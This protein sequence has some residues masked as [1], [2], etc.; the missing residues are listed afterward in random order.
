[1]PHIHVLPDSVSRLI[2]AGEVVQRPANAVKELIE[3]ALDANAR[4]VEIEIRD[5]GLQLI[6]VSDDGH[7]IEADDLPLAVLR[8]ATSKLRS[9]EDLERI[10]TFGF[11]GEALASI[12]EW[13]ELQLLSR[14]QGAANAATLRVVYGRCEAVRPAA[15]RPGTTVEVRGLFARL[16]AR[17]EYLGSS[18][19][20]SQAIARVV[21]T[22]AIGAPHVRFV[23]I[24]DD[25]TVLD[26]AA[27]NDP[28]ERIAE[29]YG[30]EFAR[31]LLPIESRYGGLVLRGFVSHPDAA[32]KRTTRSTIFVNDRPVDLPALRGG[33]RQAYR[34]RI[35]ADRVP[36]V[37]VWLD[38]Q[39][40]AVDPNVAPDKSEVRLRRDA[41]HVGA[42][43][44]Q[45]AERALATLDAVA[46]VPVD[47]R[48]TVTWSPSIRVFQPRPLEAEKATDLFSSE[49]LLGTSKSP[50]TSTPTGIRLPADPP[51]LYQLARSFL[52]APTDEGLLYVDQH[53]LH[54]RILYEELSTKAEMMDRQALLE[55]ETIRFASADAALG[56]EEQIDVLRTVGFEIESAGLR[57]YW[58]QTVPAWIG[59]KDPIRALRDALETLERSPARDESAV[60]SRLFRSLACRAAV[61]AGQSLS[62]EEIRVLWQAGLSLDLALLD[63]HGRPGAVLIRHDEIARRLDRKLPV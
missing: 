35:G 42:L 55:P 28:V 21:Q 3:N 60:S 25:R 9:V 59:V 49:R 63:V 1:M 36:E 48:P 10:R 56:F 62:E 11:R 53:S 61:K 38:V 26:V 34:S 2:A 14:A 8:H 20:E 7:G 6:R 37:I 45:A 22:A 12:A 47:H 23:L 5:G 18:R 27:T 44:Y 33:I 13:A 40:S 4:T 39:P 43:A 19:A 58:I 54:E 32:P 30:N 24:L 52:V 16:P 29:I 17:L 15:R 50:S 41:D 57:T 31:G 51:F 46:A